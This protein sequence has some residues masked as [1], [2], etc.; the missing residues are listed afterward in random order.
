MRSPR[1]GRLAAAGRLAVPFLTVLASLLTPLS[2]AAA[3]QVSGVVVDQSGNVLPRASVRA[4]S[5]DGRPLGGTFSDEA[6]RFRMANLAAG[7]TVEATLT[8]F[9]PSR[10]ACAATPLRLVLAVAPVEETVV[11]TATR[12][13]AP[14]GLVGASVT[15]FSA[16]DLERRR[17]PLLADLLRTSPGATVVRVGGLG[18][19]TSLF[20]RGGES[21]HNKVLL[22]GIPL[23]EPGGTFNF[24]N[25]TTAG[26]ER[27]EIVRGAQSALFGSDAMAGVVQLF[28]ER[29]GQRTGPPHVTGALEFGTFT[30]LRGE[31]SAS[32]RLGP[33]D[34]AAGGSR[35]N[36]DNQ[37]ANNAFDNTTLW[38]N[39]GIRLADGAT[40]RFVGRGE[41]EQVGVPGATSFGRADLDASFRR[42]DA[43]GGVTFNG[44]SALTLRHRA[45]YS[46]GVTTQQS[47]NLVLDPPY[48]PRFEDRIS[49]FTFF[50]FTTDSMNHLRR[51]HASYQVDWRLSSGERA[52]DHLLTLLADWD[53]E[54]AN[55]EDRLAGTRTRA[56]RNN[57][58]TS[59][60]HQ[61]TWRRIA[62][63][64]GARFERNGSFGSA[65]VPRGSIVV[66][67]RRARG[68]LGETKARA[69]GG[70]GIKEPTVLQSFS[71]SPFFLGNPHLEPERSRS[72]EAGVEQRFASDRARVEATWFAN[73][74]RNL[75]STRSTNAESF[76]A[77]YFNV[78]LT[79]ARGVELA[80]HLAAT[81]TIEVRAGYTFLD[82]AVLESTAPGDIVF[83]R[84]ESLFRRPRHSGYAGVTVAWRR[85]AADLSA[86]F[87]GRFVDSDFALL[88]PPLTA[89]PGHD[90][91]DARL[92]YRL[93]QH[94]TLQLAIDNA[95]DARYSEPLGYPA[96]G[97][98]IRAG[99]R[100]TF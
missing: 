22:D 86:V 72:V 17:A 69:S 7:C 91:M 24:G 64:G 35:L 78:G 97:R 11:V 81:R 74:S 19:I 62:V 49:P 60:Q 33:A 95:T 28:T 77:Q 23:N 99:A 65:F 93:A 41:L 98:A 31:G 14:A 34:Y 32:G 1:S 29:A 85:L 51:H 25:L 89:N 6:G 16:D 12:T 55:L 54:R 2:A 38:A 39:A 52:G 15:T 18:N 48:V 50:D 57:V 83:R 40:L 88:D 20:V 21:N 44:S 71:L 5:A 82:S 67:A 100:M 47:R 76:T 10:A 80:A 43:V 94:L 42:R 87:I 73:R 36:T 13:E 45:S 9:E 75:I 37:V 61:A 58:G 70:L 63:T 8:G 4:A 56:A 92:S 79:R 27:V 26:L 68:A 59:V 66:V 30:T 90:T 46:L 84:G 96:L 3:D 53:A